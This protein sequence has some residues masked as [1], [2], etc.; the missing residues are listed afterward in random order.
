MKVKGINKLATL[1]T[2]AT[3]VSC[4]ENSKPAASKGNILD[5]NKVLNNDSLSSS[6]KA[7][8]LA[9][10]AE[11]LATP[12]GFMYADLILDQALKLD[13][14]NL[15]ANFY[16]ALLAQP[17][18]L[19]GAMKRIKPLA[20]RD[21]ESLNRYNEAISNL[22]ESA[23]KT[24]MFDGQENI[25][26]EKD[27][28]GFV[29]EIYNAQEKFR[30]FLKQNKNQVITL[31][32]SD[33][34]KAST[35]SQTVKECAVE[36]VGTG[37]FSLKACDL[38]KSL[39]IEL[40]RADMEALQYITAGS[41]IYLSL[42]TAYDVSGAINVAQNT[43]GQ[44]LTNADAWRKLA[45]N[46]D[47]GKL[48][49]TRVLQNIPEMGLDAIIGIR[50]AISM[51]DELCPTGQETTGARKGQLFSKGLCITNTTNED[52]STL[53]DSLRVIDLALTGGLVEIKKNDQE[54]TDLKAV[55][56]LENPIADLKTLKPS[57]N[58]CDKVS[59]IADDSL[60]GSLPNN[61]AN[62][63]LANSSKCDK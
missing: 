52:G 17:M 31:N 7:E 53:E 5:S 62:D 60:N 8:E 44:T 43:K 41:Q 10:I 13:S 54:K 40:N 34:G 47:F 61:D 23:L 26:T 16:K 36:Q 32:M 57:F 14:N 27:V 58:E 56:L 11:Q 3:L 59:S 35:F 22:P 1:L 28:Q 15:R 46:A 51:Q 45:R 38:R 37:T 18:A 33:W 25:R 30:L 49:N 12:T 42:I 39:Q 20:Q 48:R 63:I 50:W 4:A 9:L 6:D 2:L 21:L 19:K 24:F 55:E 29:D